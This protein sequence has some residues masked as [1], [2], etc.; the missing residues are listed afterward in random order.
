MFGERRGSFSYL[1]V[2]ASPA[3]LSGLAKVTDRRGNQ[4]RGKKSSEVFSSYVRWR[5]LR[6]LRSLSCT[7]D[8]AHCVFVGVST[9]VVS[10][11]KTARPRFT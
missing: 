7:L 11:A 1:K 8:F 5:T 10:C 4:P 2:N 9:D 6:A 3:E